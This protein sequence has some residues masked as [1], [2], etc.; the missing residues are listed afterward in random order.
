MTACGPLPSTAFMPGNAGEVGSFHTVHDGPWRSMVALV[1]SYDLNRILGLQTYRRQR[2]EKK[3]HM[4]KYTI[5]IDIFQRNTLDVHRLVDGPEKHKR[6]INGKTGH[7]PS[8]KW[9]GVWVG[10]FETT[11]AYHRLVERAL[12]TH[13]ASVCRQEPKTSAQV[14]CSG[15][16]A[17]TDLMLVRDVE[18]GYNFTAGAKTSHRRRK[19]GP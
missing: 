8:V 6:F 19:S 13:S 4:D 5:G 10:V 2:L 16:L 17:K 11:G 18:D 1:F 7:T 14:Y 3:E 12:G 9:L 15:K